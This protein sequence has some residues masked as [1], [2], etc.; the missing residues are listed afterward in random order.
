MVQEINGKK[1]EIIKWLREFG[2][3]P[4]SRFVGL[5]GI[6]YEAIKKVLELLEE[7]KILIKEEETQ[8]TYW[9]LNEVENDRNKKI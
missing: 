7:E 2:R 9:K 8:A 6:D 1:E 3:L 5:M 4:T